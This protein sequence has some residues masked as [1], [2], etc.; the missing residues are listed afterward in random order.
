MLGSLSR[1]F[2]MRNSAVNADNFAGTTRPTSLFLFPVTRAQSLFSAFSSIKF[3]N[4]HD[5]SMGICPASVSFWFDISKLQL[6]LNNGLVPRHACLAYI[7]VLD[8]LLETTQTCKRDV[9]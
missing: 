3:F 1:I 8:Q 4:K 2:A 6:R 7:Q 5:N 9:L